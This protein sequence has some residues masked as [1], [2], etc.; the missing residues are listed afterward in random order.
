MA[1]KYINNFQS[2]ALQNLPKLVLLGLKINHLATLE[3]APKNSFLEIHKRN[4]LEKLVKTRGPVL[5]FSSV[6]TCVKSHWF[7]RA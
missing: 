6:A 4:Q 5:N 2:K 3:H 7:C 1:I